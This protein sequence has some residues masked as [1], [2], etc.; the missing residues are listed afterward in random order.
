MLSA[1]PQIHRHRT[2]HGEAV[3]LV[4]PRGSVTV[5]LTVH[6]LELDATTVE[7][8]LHA[9]LGVLA[10]SVVGEGRDRI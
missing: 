10:V 3:T 7:R 1:T 8:L 5:E 9:P 2:R 4:T 6:G